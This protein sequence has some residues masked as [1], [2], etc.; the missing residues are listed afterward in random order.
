MHRGTGACRDTHTSS[1]NT[2]SREN[3]CC[4]TSHTQL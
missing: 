4:C 3:Q 2:Q 1:N